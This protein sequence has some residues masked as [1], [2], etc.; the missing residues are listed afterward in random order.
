MHYK[1]KD[2]VDLDILK[3]YGYERIGGINSIKRY[4]KETDDVGVCI[5]FDREIVWYYFPYILFVYN[6]KTNKQYIKDLIDAGL[7][8]EVNDD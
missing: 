2:D 6:E 5:L 1:I 8:E 4:V 7:V 3:K